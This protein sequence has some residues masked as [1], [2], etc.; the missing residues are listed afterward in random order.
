MIVTTAYDPDQSTLSRAFEITALLNATFIK[1]KKQSLNALFEL[2]QEI[3]IV[4]KESAKYYVNEQQQPFFFHPSMAVLR[5]NRLQKGDNDI[6]VSLSQ[7]KSGD[8]FLDC[9]MGLGSDSIV[10]SYIVGERG[11]VVGIESEPVIGI[12]V[13][14]GLQR[15]WKQD[16]D[17]DAAMKQ[18]EI[19]LSDHLEFLKLLPDQS[20][21]IVYFDPM[22]RKGVKKSSSIAPLRKLANSNPLTIETIEQAKRVAKRAV[23]LKENKNSKEFERLGFTK[24][25]R[26]SSTT[27]GIIKVDREV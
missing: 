22:F 13:K 16:P 11:R 21:D 2:D 25:S 4:E 24:I 23:V 15:G 20:F 14:D 27:Y 7:L 9:T 26:S 19:R 8:T 3:I 5:I 10:A 6:L 17:I 12:L 18:I 1:R